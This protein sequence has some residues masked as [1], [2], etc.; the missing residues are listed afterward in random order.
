MIVYDH[1]CNN[2]HSKSNPLI[3]QQT[4]NQEINVE[5]QITNIYEFRTYI[6]G[7][8]CENF[9]NLSGIENKFA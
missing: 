5:Y 2:I 1:P 6:S 4:I 7:T 9:D 8:K 3:K